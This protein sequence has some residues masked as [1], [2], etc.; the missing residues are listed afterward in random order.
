MNKR[1]IK[2]NSLKF[3]KFNTMNKNGLTMLQKI[4]LKPD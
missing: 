3:N 2:S 1:A 4:S